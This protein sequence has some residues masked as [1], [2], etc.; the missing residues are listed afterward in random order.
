LPELAARA[1]AYQKMRSPGCKLAFHS[2][3]DHDDA[4]FVATPDGN[5]ITR[6]LAGW[7]A[8]WSWSGTR[9][10][11]DKEDA[12]WVVDADG[13][14]ATMIGAGRF[15][16][17]APDD[18]HIVY[19]DSTEGIS[20]MGSDGSNPTQLIDF[21]TIAPGFPAPHWIFDVVWGSD[22]TIVY[23]AI[24][25]ISSDWGATVWRVAS[26]GSSQ[27][28]VDTSMQSPLLAARYQTADPHQVVTQDSDP[29]D[30]YSRLVVVNRDTGLSHLA[31]PSPESPLIGLW[32]GRLLWALPF[33][34]HYADDTPACAH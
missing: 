32:V 29:V 27:A 8:S 15:A 10:A 14:G 4:I 18:Q 1:N 28:L 9:L 17:W 30:S 24:Y 2:T 23:G 33:Y 12:I 5:T 6:V 13:G 22:N 21:D 31:L 34:S 11:I 20:I 7:R 3:R 25:P 19:V 16:D 26:N